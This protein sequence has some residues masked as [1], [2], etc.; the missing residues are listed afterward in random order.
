VIRNVARHLKSLPNNPPRI[1]P[2]AHAARVRERV[3][4]PNAM[5]IGWLRIHWLGDLNEEAR[6]LRICRDLFWLAA[7]GSA[8]AADLPVKAPPPLQPS[9]PALVYNGWTGWYLGGNV[10][11][12]F[13]N[14]DTNI[15]G[16]AATISFTFIKMANGEG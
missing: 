2:H 6:Y 1:L 8:F 16:S 3:F 5:R 15:A 4:V 9:A 7:S 14:A 11:Y 10:G 12:G 13:G